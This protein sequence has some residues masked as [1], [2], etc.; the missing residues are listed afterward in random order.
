MSYNIT[1]WKTKKIESLVI[2]I[3]SFYKYK[4]SSWHP[5]EPWRGCQPSEDQIRIEGGAEGFE[6]SGTYLEPADGK[7]AVAVRDIHLSGE[8][9]GTFYHNVLVPALEDST[10]YLQ[11][12][13]IWEGGDSITRLVVIDGKVARMEVEL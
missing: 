1:T 2:P 5:D 13:L 3:D 9:S 4:D 8:C 11:S 7:V 12:V 6:L 10:G